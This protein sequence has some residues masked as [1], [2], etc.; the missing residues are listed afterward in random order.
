MSSKKPS[1]KDLLQT[2]DQAQKAG[3]PARAQAIYAAILAKFPKHGKAKKELSRLQKITGGTANRMTAADAQQLGEM[4]NR[5]MFPEV[6]DQVRLLMVHNRKEP[7]LYNIQ[8]LAQTNLDQNKPAISSFKHAI[9]LNPAFAEAQNN[10]GL[11]YIKNGD[12]AAALPPLQKAI[13]L[14]PTYAEAHHNLGVALA[15]LEDHTAS[16]AAYDK[17]L[18]LR[19]DYANAL[20]SRGNLLAV[21]K[22]YDRAT[23][24]MKA[25]L[26]LVPNDAEVASNL[27]AVLSEQ[28]QAEAAIEYATRA[29]KLDPEN[30]DYLAT[31]AVY[32]NAAGQVEQAR[33]CLHDLIDRK[34][35]HGDA[36]LS[37][38]G[39]EK[40]KPDS[41][42]IGQVEDA[43][44]SR[45]A[46]ENDRV[47]LGFALAKMRED[48]GDY[49]PAFKALQAAN[50]LN[51]TLLEN[52][53]MDQD[54]AFD[55]IKQAFT[56]ET[57]AAAAGQGNPSEVPVFVVGLMRSGTSLVE[58][59]LASHSQVH[60]GGERMFA[61]DLVK[62]LR[63][64]TGFPDATQIA[65]FGARYVEQLQSLAP[66]AAHITDKMPANFFYIGLIKLALP[67]AKIINLVRDPRDNGYS[68][69]KNFFD[70]EAHRYAYDL[71]DLARFA[72][73]YKSLMNHWHDLFEGQI[74]DCV[75]EDLIADQEAES[76]KLLNYCDLEWEPQVLDFHKTKR[77]V[78]TA[79]VNQV[80]R[81]IYKSS[82]RSWEHVADQLTPFVERLDRD[83]WAQ[84]LK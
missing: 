82:V 20:N 29:V 66:E 71:P 83:L 31:L 33:A 76:R 23:A 65:E 30:T 41:A 24:D 67:N 49:E 19:P 54:A 11:V 77:A 62:D 79:S 38:A 37:L 68:I 36:F 10:L 43:L 27:G 40:T 45:Q 63:I 9:R 35:T 73:Q 46:S 47:R 25:A 42:L 74:Y 6:L 4:L 81:R 32:L 72:N 59:I 78:R 16:L 14:K 8:G 52:S 50:A 57:V 84:Y 44:K 18:E 70:T 21:M 2:A 58:Q 17:A 5:G 64:G 80:R 39:M 61:T 34:P 69:Y 22:K 56:K 3:D 60:G 26:A 1:I 55:A 13:S 75:Y 28:G 51:Y 53:E 15:A 12:A 7:F 48:L